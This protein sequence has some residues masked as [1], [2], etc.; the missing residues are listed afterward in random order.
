MHT[1]SNGGK[2]KSYPS[3]GNEGPDGGKGGG[4]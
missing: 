4:E 1:A 3:T 2:G